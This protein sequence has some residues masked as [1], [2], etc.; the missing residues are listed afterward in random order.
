M[1]GSML[2]FVALSCFSCCMAQVPGF[3]SCPTVTVKDDFDLSKV[4]IQD[5]YR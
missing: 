1:K 3:G 5:S 2:M 4:R